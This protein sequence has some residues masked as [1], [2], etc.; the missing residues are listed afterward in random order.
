MCEELARLFDTRTGHFKLES[1]H[2][3]DLWIDLNALLL[4]PRRLQR[5]AEVLAQRLSMHQVEAVCGP[6]VGGAFVAQTVAAEL[7]IEFYYAER[8]VRSQHDG[9]SAVAYRVPSP[10]RD[11][12]NGKRVALVDDVINAG[13][14]VRATWVDLCECGAR[15]PVIGAL[16]VLGSSA[17]TFA[18]DQQVPL[19]SMS[20]RSSGQWLR[21]DCPF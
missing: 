19:E 5:F 6:L 10:L 7:D 2:H 15:P 13:S 14:A 21:I 12:L 11:K 4:R 18:A 8:T 3:G 16:L 17:A 1:G 20:H 9:P